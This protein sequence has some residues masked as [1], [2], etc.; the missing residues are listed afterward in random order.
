MFVFFGSYPTYYRNCEIRL[1][2][3]DESWAGGPSNPL[4]RLS[5]RWGCHILNI[6]E[7]LEKFYTK[8][9]ESIFLGYYENNR[10]FRVYNRRAFVIEEAIHVTFDECNDD[11]S[12]SSYEDDDVGVQEGLKELTIHD[13][14]NA[15]QEESS[16][17]DDPQN[18]QALEENGNHDDAPRDLPKA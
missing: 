12:K 3:P 18:N 1:R 5:G 9:D 14:N 6:K 11:I 8:S 4:V 7:H 16:K 15:P 17:K 10:G 13:Q 2:S